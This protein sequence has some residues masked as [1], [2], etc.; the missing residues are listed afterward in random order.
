ME[1]E[2]E[3]KRKLAEQLAKARDASVVIYSIGPEE[4]DGRR[5][6]WFYRHRHGETR[7]YMGIVT[8]EAEGPLSLWRKKNWPSARHDLWRPAL[9]PIAGHPD[10]EIITREVVK[11]RCRFCGHLNDQ[12]TPKCVQCGAPT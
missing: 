10:K 9:P 11:I 5:H 4:T 6:I 7:H 8:V 2:A 1:L 12:G 3:V